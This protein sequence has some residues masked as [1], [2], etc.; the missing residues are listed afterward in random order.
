MY[1]LDEVRMT[2]PGDRGRDLWQKK[3]GRTAIL[4]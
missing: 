3:K 2:D 1:S 4:S